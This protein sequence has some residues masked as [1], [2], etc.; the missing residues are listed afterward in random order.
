MANAAATGFTKRDLDEFPD[1]SDDYVGKL[2]LEFGEVKIS[3]ATSY[4]D[5]R[6][7][8][9][10][11]RMRCIGGFGGG[12]RYAVLAV[13]DVIEQWR[14]SFEP[15]CTFCLMLGSYVLILTI[16]PSRWMSV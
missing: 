3:F 6:R 8:M 11:H 1:R 15:I 4:F 13:T 12:A 2:A 5:L 7:K 16:W 10:H 9:C 14:L